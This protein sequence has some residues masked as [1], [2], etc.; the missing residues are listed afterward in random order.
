MLNKLKDKIFLTIQIERFPLAVISSIFL[1]VTGWLFFYT[2]YTNEFLHSS[3]PYKLFGVF[4]DTFL[5]KSAILFFWCYIFFVAL[6]L[7]KEN[8][9]ERLPLVFQALATSVFAII[10]AYI[11]YFYLSPDFHEDS[12]FWQWL[13]VFAYTAVL[14]FT[15]FLSPYLNKLNEDFNLW[16]F[17]QKVLISLATTVFFTASILLGLLMALLAIKALLGVN[18]VFVSDPI[19]RFGIDR[20]TGFN[21]YPYVWIFFVFFYGFNLFLTLLPKEFTFTEGVHK[22]VEVFTKYIV[23]IFLLFY[24]LICFVYLFKILLTGIWPESGVVYTLIWLLIPAAVHQLLN[25][26]FKKFENITFFESY[27]QK[28]V[29][30]S[31]LPVV[32]VYLYAI[33]SRTF[34][35]GVTLNRYLVLVTGL[36]FLGFSLYY[37]LSK[38]QRLAYIFVSTILVIIVSILVPYVNANAISERSQLNRLEDLFYKHNILPADNSKP[39]VLSIE[40]YTAITDT[41]EYLCYNHSLDGVYSLTGVQN[42]SD[43]ELYCWDDVDYLASSLNFLANGRSNKDSF[44]HP[45]EQYIYVRTNHLTETSLLN[46][47]KYSNLLKFSAMDLELQDSSNERVLHV[48]ANYKLVY[49]ENVNPYSL[50]LYDVPTNTQ[51]ATINIK[52]QLNAYMLTKPTSNDFEITKTVVVTTPKI[53]G[54]GDVTLLITELWGII[55]GREQTIELQNLSGELLF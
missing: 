47:Q 54:S 44:R 1:T 33:L 13:V 46:I 24:L 20:E 55:K 23:R 10:S 31:L 8:L 18:L 27:V 35:Y 4:S 51:L 37:L 53:D 28:W 22:L 26:P 42:V 49:V 5:F 2:V 15:A 17:C 34:A 30:L 40:D 29:Y 48:D 12:A 41:I 25:Y 6:K 52:D 14:V 43:D 9:R 38:T 39:K 19:G 16:M 36:W 3:T 50:I 32:G 21:L 7:F 45:V 11:L